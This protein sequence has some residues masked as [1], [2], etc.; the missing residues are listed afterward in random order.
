MYLGG[1]RVSSV[2]KKDDQSLGGMIVIVDTDNGM[3]NTEIGRRERGGS[4]V[5]IATFN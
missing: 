1:G 5:S 3:A 4:N 2:V